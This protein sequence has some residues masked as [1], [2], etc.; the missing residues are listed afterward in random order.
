VVH[1]RSRLVLAIACGLGGA[2]CTE[3]TCLLIDA[4]A[5]VDYGLLA[6]LFVPFLAGLGILFGTLDC[7]AG[8][9]LFV[10][11]HR[12]KSRRLGIVGGND[13]P[14]FSGALGGT[15]RHIEG[16]QWCPI[17]CATSGC[18]CQCPLGIAAH[19][20]LSTKLI[21]VRVLHASL[22]SHACLTVPSMCQGLTAWALLP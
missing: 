13:T 1:R 21:V 9:C 14:F 17:M 22:R 12:S 2:L 18:P 20:P 10:A 7:G 6:A 15:D 8:Q 19:P 5:V 3:A 4:A 11:R 16:S